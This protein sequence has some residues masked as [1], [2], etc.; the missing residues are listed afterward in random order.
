M[1]GELYGT[2]SLLR[3][4]F[5]C[6]STARTGG[7]I[8]SSIEI[9]FSCIHFQYPLMMIPNGVF[10]H[11]RLANTVDKHRNRFQFF[12]CEAFW[13]W[14]VQWSYLF[15][16][17][18]CQ[19]SKYFYLT[20]KIMYLRGTWCF[21]KIQNSGHERSNV[22]PIVPSLTAQACKKNVVGRCDGAT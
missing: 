20:D 22:R 6:I 14:K 21:F 9:I 3:S 4:L 11:K 19:S 5:Y 2:M 1:V 10:V 12:L 15:E 7:Y 16:I 8:I 13:H 18:L 17:H